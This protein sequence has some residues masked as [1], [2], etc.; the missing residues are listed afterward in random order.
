ML[1]LFVDILLQYL[2][3]VRSEIVNNCI[4]ADS[5][6]KTM[7]LVIILK[8]NKNPF[9]T[10]YRLISLL[11]NSY[12]IIVSFLAGRLNKVWYK[13]INVDKY[14]LLTDRQWKYSIRSIINKIYSTRTS[15][16]TNHVLRSQKAFD[17]IEWHWDLNEHG[18]F[19]LDWWNRYDILLNREHF[20]MYEQ[21]K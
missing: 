5:R 15:R 14:N 18:N 10:P 7:A 6:N 3:S 21:I 19:P 17:N 20:F 8:L 13:Y 12:K 11:N 16:D 9:V 1:W 4:L 2:A